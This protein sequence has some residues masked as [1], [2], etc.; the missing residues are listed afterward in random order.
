MGHPDEVK[1]WRCYACDDLVQLE[2]DKPGNAT[3]HMKSKHGWRDLRQTDPSEGGSVREYSPTPTSSSRTTGPQQQ[4]IFTMLQQGFE[5]SGAEWR[6]NCLQWMV[7]THQPL[8][9]VDHPSFRRMIEGITPKM[10]KYLFGRNA[11][12]D[13]VESE[14]E[15][16]KD[17]IRDLIKESVTRIHISMD[18]W[19]AKFSKFGILGVVAHFATRHT[20]KVEVAGTTEERVEFKRRSVLLALR[21]LKEAHAGEYEA[22]ILADVIKE[23][24]FTDNLGVCVADNAGENNTSVRALFRTLYPDL[25]DLTG[26]RVRCL[27]H[28]FNLAAK[29]YLYGAKKGGNKAVTEFEEAVRSLEVDDFD[30]ESARAL[31]HEQGSLGKLH[32]LVK[33]IRS[34]SQRKEEFR[35]IR[36]G[37]LNTDGKWLSDTA[38]INKNLRYWPIIT[39]LSD[40]TYGPTR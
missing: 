21:R 11:A 34:S 16:A 13:A 24:D 3:K 2:V 33:F 23:Y 5:P 9:A 18:V 29:A 7:E 27:A 38:R 35:G 40:R 12:R 30:W 31:W 37:S 20:L 6:R 15:A 14:F 36:T 32:N 22:T 10:K 25:K 28:I 1:A 4:S 8:S 17:K 26:K 39:N 19:T